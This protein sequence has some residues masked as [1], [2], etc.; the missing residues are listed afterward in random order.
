MEMRSQV[1]QLMECVQTRLVFVLK[2]DFKDAE[3]KV[4]AG[5]DIIN[6]ENV[7]RQDSFS[8]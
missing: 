2:I 6:S 3:A 4:W 5:H 7:V 1:F 8:F